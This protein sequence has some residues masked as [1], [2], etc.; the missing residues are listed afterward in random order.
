MD[1][2]IGKNL[3]KT[4]FNSNKKH[5]IGPQSSMWTA[6]G[7]KVWVRRREED[8]LSTVAAG[9]GHQLSVASAQ[10]V[11]TLDTL[12]LMLLLLMA[13]VVSAQSAAA[14]EHLLQYMPQYSAGVFQKDWQEE[15]AP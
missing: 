1:I 6:A 7:L 12:T 2:I 15:S 3:H 8:P 13:L 14:D 9:N 5:P 10:C 11:D 4:Q